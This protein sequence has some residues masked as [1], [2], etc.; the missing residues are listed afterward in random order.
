[1]AGVSNLQTW[2]WEHLGD[3]NTLLQTRTLQLSLGFF[4]FDLSF[5]LWHR[6]ESPLMLLHHAACICGLGFGLVTGVGGAELVAVVAGGELTN[7]AL[8]TRWFFLQTRQYRGSRLARCND[9][10]FIVTFFLIRVVL[11]TY[12]MYA[13]AASPRV[14]PVVKA[15][16]AC[17]YAISLLWFGA[18]AERLRDGGSR[19]LLPANPPPITAAPTP[20]GSTAT[21]S[22][23]ATGAPGPSATTVAPPKED[24]MPPPTHED[25]AVHLGAATAGDCGGFGS[26]TALRR[27][28]RAA[29]KLS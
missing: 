21:S 2:P 27:R 10:I 5:R 18:M 11:G 13:V 3:A 1:M 26:P 23:N 7:L 17:L 6:D 19:A 12:H 25:P 4:L 22:S 9:W 28:R 29:T 24:S 8:E 15:G 20:D 16:G 14:H